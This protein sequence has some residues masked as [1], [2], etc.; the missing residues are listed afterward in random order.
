MAGERGINLSGGQR[1]RV[2]L[3]R[4]AYHDAGGSADP[5]SGAN[6]PMPM[7]ASNVLERLQWSSICDRHFPIFPSPAPTSATLPACWLPQIWSC[8][9]TH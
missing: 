3:A 6:G 5:R 2:A 9:T 4:A 8:W 7:Q 1:Q